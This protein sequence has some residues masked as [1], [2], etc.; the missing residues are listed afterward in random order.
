MSEGPIYELGSMYGM[1]YNDPNRP[2]IMNH[3]DNDSDD[4]EID[5]DIERTLGNPLQH[6]GNMRALQRNM[7]RFPTNLTPAT[8]LKWGTEM[9]QYLHDEQDDFVEDIICCQDWL[10]LL[11]NNMHTKRI[12]Q[13]ENGTQ[14]VYSTEFEDAVEM[15][16]H[17]LRPMSWNF[18][19]KVLLKKKV[20]LI[21][22]LLF[23]SAIQKVITTYDIIGLLKVFT[24]IGYTEQN[25]II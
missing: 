1:K 16:Q 20:H 12:L 2:R 15:K 8:Y 22:N 6:G 19:I 7:P 9:L 5:A 21:F 18:S 4:E 24:E 23:F 10:I 11:K 14:F 25:L 3:V 17:Q 13:K